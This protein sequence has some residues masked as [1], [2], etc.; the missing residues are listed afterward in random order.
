MRA[1][2]RRDRLV[3]R[4]RVIEDSTYRF[5]YPVTF[6]TMLA[7]PAAIGM[8]VWKEQLFD[9]RV[10]VRR[11]LQYLFART[12]LQ[13]LL[14]LPIALLMFSVLRNP[15]RTIAQV[16]TQGSGWVNV[17]LIGV[18]GTILPSRHRLR[19]ALDRKF[20]RETYEQE[21][22]LARMIED[23]RQRD[24]LREVARLVGDCGRV[25]RVGRPVR[26][27]LRAFLKIASI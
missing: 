25:R 7:I 10:I 14:A 11:G 1:V 16:V 17:A 9:V 22:V 12:A 26:R 24:S 5:W 19:S 2:H 21:Q 3:P 15:N 23:V 20:F 4:V 6:V 18:I 8:A 13:A 27:L